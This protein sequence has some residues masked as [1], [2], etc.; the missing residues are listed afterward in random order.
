MLTNRQKALIHV[1]KSKIGMTDPEYRAL[2]SGFGVE[3]S[4]QLTQGQ[5]DRVMRQ[6]AAIGFKATR[7]APPKIKTS[8]ERLRAKVSAILRD[9]H[10]TD[11]YADAIASSRFGVDVWRWLQTDDLYRLVAMLAYHQRRHPESRRELHV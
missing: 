11:S 10:L 7:A 9:L 2:L 4:T 5:F 8:R 1:A 6:F 3:S